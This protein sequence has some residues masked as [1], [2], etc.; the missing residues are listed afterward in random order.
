MKST[1]RL[2]RGG[3]IPGVPTGHLHRVCGDDSDREF[4]I[5][6]GS[7][8][9]EEYIEQL[10]IEVKYLENIIFFDR[11]LGYGRPAIIRQARVLP[12]NF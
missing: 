8:C 5:D 9:S 12:D 2:F 4:P 11:G 3:F 7:S 10:Y 6:E 1:L